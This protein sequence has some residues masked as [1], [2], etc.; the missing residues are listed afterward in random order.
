MANA[1]MASIGETGVDGGPGHSTINGFSDAARNSA[2][3]NRSAA[4]RVHSDGLDGSGAGADVGPAEAARVAPGTA[5]GARSAAM[6]A[7]FMFLLIS[8]Q[9]EAPFS[10]A[11]FGALFGDF[12]NEQGGFYIPAQKPDLPAS[13]TLAHDFD[14]PRIQTPRPLRSGTGKVMEVPGLSVEIQNRTERCCPAIFRKASAP[15]SRRKVVPTAARPVRA[16]CSRLPSDARPFQTLKNWT[17]FLLVACCCQRES[18]GS[19]PASAT[20][21]GGRGRQQISSL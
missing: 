10:S 3:E 11:A 8:F 15:G 4:E 13:S 21:R 12:K 19:P 16:A 2:H 7:C 6:M 14:S 20:H 17:S 18:A 9:D 5:S 1:W